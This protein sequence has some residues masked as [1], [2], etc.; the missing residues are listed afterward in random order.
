MEF[1]AGKALSGMPPANLAGM[2]SKPR[3]L[4]ALAT[5][6]LLLLLPLAAK[7]DS[8]EPSQPNII[9]ILADDLGVETLGVY[10]RHVL[11]DAGARPDRGGGSAL[12][13]T[14]TH[15]RFPRRPGSS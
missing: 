13:E 3:T 9:V 1:R 15:S 12:R 10:G 8:Q 14:G 11:R 5:T 6:A 7:T 2:S 4:A